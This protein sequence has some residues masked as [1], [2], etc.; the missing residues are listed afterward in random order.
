MQGEVV[1]WS[2]NWEGLYIEVRSFCQL[3]QK[4]D[5]NYV[6]EDGKV[7]ANK[8]SE[9]LFE[10]QEHA[11]TLGVPSKILAH[12][13]DAIGKVRGVEHSGHVCSLGTGV[14]PSSIFGLP[15]NSINYV[16]FG[17]L[18]NNVNNKY[19]QDLKKQVETL[20]EKLI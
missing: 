20:Q 3:C 11:A 9:H 6:N 19:I 10:D 17:G 13:D 8:I 12:C 7:L 14:C 2:V 15:K 1:K 16:N 4:K 18:G 5:G